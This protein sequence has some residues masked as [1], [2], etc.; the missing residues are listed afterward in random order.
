[1][2]VQLNW[3]QE[4][5]I[6]LKGGHVIDPK[7]NINEI[8]DVAILEDKVVAVSKNIDAKK[9]RQ[10]VD[11]KGMYVTPGLIDIHSHNF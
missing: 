11:V 4:Y 3:A 2:S 9:A 7:N 1:L 6:L 10:V 8:M 5:S